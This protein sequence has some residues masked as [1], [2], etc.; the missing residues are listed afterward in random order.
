MV[1]SC[2]PCP[3]AAARSWTAW[4][5]SAGTMMG[6]DGNGDGAAGTG[7]AAP[8]CLAPLQG[9]SVR[10]WPNERCPGAT[11]PSDNSASTELPS[12]AQPVVRGARRPSPSEDSESGEGASDRTSSLD[13]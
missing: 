10:T 4:V 12:P 7:G 2:G 3:V 6:S 9:L 1:K 5:E 11:A 13:E 8:E